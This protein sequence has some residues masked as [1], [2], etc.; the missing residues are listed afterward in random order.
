MAQVLFT[1]SFKYS[2]YIQIEHCYETFLELLHSHLNHAVK[3]I[4][5]AI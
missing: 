3:G 5:V 1:I 4:I 2:S